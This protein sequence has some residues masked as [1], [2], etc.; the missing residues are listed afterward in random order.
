MM[1]SYSSLPAAP[2]LFMGTSVAILL[3]LALSVAPPAAGEAVQGS[4]NGT[5]TMARTVVG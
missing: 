5:V 3:L 1:R 4:C 2:H